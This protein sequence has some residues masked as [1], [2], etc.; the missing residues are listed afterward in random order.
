LSFFCLFILLLLQAKLS[1]PPEHGEA[2]DE[3]IGL[4]G[5]CKASCS[6]E[7]AKGA[8][9]QKKKAPPA[10]FYTEDKRL[11]VTIRSVFHPLSFALIIDAPFLSDRLVLQ[12]CAHWLPPLECPAEGNAEQELAGSL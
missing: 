6:A 5:C 9:C 4:C 7:A 1:H 12:H 11:S 3:M 8:C 2:G 10:T